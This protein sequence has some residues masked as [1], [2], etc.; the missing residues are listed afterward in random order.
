MHLP[1][2][3]G[4]IFC[5]DSSSTFGNRAAPGDLWKEVDLLKRIIHHQTTK[6]NNSQKKNHEVF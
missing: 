1:T 6:D 4:S 5:G 2:S 3:M